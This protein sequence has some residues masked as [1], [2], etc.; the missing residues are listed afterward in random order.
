MGNAGVLSSTAGDLNNQKRARGHLLELKTALQAIQLI[1]TGS[2]NEGSLTNN[3]V[4]VSLTL[5]P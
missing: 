1:N 3:T 4:I 2:L 5:N